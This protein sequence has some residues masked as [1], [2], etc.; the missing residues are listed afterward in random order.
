MSF[1]AMPVRSGGQK[2]AAPVTGVILAGGEGRRMGNVSKSL[3]LLDDRPIIDHVVG[4]FGPQ[5][6][7]LLINANRDDEG[8]R[9]Y[10]VPVVED[11]VPNLPG[12][13]A[14]VLAAM[15]WMHAQPDRKDR[16]QW[17]VSVPADSPFVPDD[18]VVRL[19]TAA[20]EHDAMTA[21][22]VRG[23]LRSPLF[24]LWSIALRYDL[25][26]QLD[27]GHR[28]VSSFQQRHRCVA[29]PF[30][31][32]EADPFFN[33][34]SPEDLETARRLARDLRNPQASRGTE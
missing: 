21:C 15:E 18:L 1:G 8:F 23:G 33:I 32:G 34:N 31:E 16:P 13:L 7:R 5:V 11:P 30:D 3:L 19:L 27:A 12:P 20:T 17:L 24:A 14:G 25:R 4:R 9:A 28:K 29:V 22:A 26:R 6:G 2:L 10:G